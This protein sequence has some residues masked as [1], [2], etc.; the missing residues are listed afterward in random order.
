MNKYFFHSILCRRFLN[1]INELRLYVS[2]NKPKTIPGAEILLCGLRLVIILFGDVAET[3]ERGGS[4]TITAVDMRW[5]SSYYFVWLT[6][7]RRQMMHDTL[8]QHS[9]DVENGPINW[10]DLSIA[11][12]HMTGLGSR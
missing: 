1:D 3:P 6:I 12:K 8:N 11:V 9:L 10:P 4:D 2:G 5:Q 7:A